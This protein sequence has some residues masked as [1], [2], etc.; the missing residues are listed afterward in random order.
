[1]LIKII[2][3]FAVLLIV[4]VIIV[5]LRP[6]EFRVTRSAVV[7]ARPEVVFEHVNDLHKWETWSPWAKL[8]PNARTQ[9]EGPPSGVGAAFSWA[10]NNQIGEGKMTI[11]ESRPHERIGFQ[12]EFVKPFKGSNVAEFTFQPQGEQTLV[13]WTMSGRNNMISKAVGL[14]LDCDK[15]VG[16]QFE[17]GLAQLDLEAGAATRK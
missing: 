4:F 10:G 9:Y 6:S 15:M 14:F 1:M 5:A 11:T 8:D 12:L 2:V 17:K 7:R 16:G 13:T 3:G